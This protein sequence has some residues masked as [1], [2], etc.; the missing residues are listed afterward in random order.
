MNSGADYVSFDQGLHCFDKAPKIDIFT[1][2][3]ES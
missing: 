3:F 2:S 1:Y